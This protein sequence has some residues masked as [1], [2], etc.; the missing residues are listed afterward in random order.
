MFERVELFLQ[1]C[2]R[3]WHVLKKPSFEEVKN[4]SKI[5]AIGLLAIGL[6]GFLISI[7]MNAFS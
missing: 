4:V 1:Q 6:I 7:V 3:V 2:L 5:T